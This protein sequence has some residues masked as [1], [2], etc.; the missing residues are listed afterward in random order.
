MGLIRGPED[1]TRVPVT[2]RSEN[3]MSG[4][5]VVVAGREGARGALAMDVNPTELRMMLALDEVVADLVDQR[6]WLSEDLLERHGNLLEHGQ[7]VD[8]GE[9][10]ARRHG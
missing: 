6:E 10:S 8:D 7:P 3:R 1:K 2:A 5:R 9:V 4:L